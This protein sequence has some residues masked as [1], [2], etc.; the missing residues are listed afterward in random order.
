MSEQL[1]CVIVGAGVVGLAVA[2]AMQQ[3]GRE[4]VILERADRFGTGVSSRSS[5]VIHGG[6]YYPPRSLKAKMCVRGREMLYRYCAERA[7]AHRKLGKIIVAT[8]EAEVVTL[9]GYMERARANAVRGM[10]WICVDELAA[11]EPELRAVAALESSETGIVDSFGLM[12]ELAHEVESRGGSLVVRSEVVGLDQ[13]GGFRLADGYA[14]RAR[15]VGNAAGLN[16]PCLAHRAW[17]GAAASSGP[18]HCKAHY[19]VFDG[20]TPFTHLVYPVAVPG[21]LGVHLTLDLDGRARFGPDVR[22]VQDL[23]YAFDDAQR[24]AFA[25]SIR[26]YYP[27]FDAGRIRP[28]YTGFRPRLSPTHDGDFCIEAAG[29]VVHLLGIESPGLTSALAIAEHVAELVHGDAT[30]FKG[31]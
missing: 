15:T 23:D 2:R 13:D 1:D 11:I 24:D 8:D 18:P 28:G 4:V 14:A 9:R 5:E 27:R 16:A 21:G 22:W 7:V 6:F 31:I 3:F 30:R 19:Y 29:A 25:E 26:R 10:R 12:T 20:P 17:A